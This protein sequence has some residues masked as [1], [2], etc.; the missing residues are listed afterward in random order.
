MKILLTRPLEDS[1]RIAKDLKELNID[2]VISPLLE[3][4]RKRDEEIDYKKYQSVLI[5]SKNAACGLC[6]SAIKKSLPIYCV[7]D[8]T[9]NFI[10]NLGFSNV[11]SASGDVSNLIRLTAANLKPSKGPI[12]YLSGQYIRYDIK[13]ELEYLDFEVD[14]SVIYEAKEVKYFNVDMLKSLEKK[15]ITGVFLYSPR[16]A[17]IFIDNMKRTKL[18]AVAPDLKV[19]C[20]SLAVADELKELKWKKVLIAHKPENAEM[21]ALVRK[22]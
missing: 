13:K 1:Q 19:Y 3:I 21:L 5:T 22:K 2:T 11:I 9:S 15:E 17:R 14:V 12:V 4:H 8:A 6:G 7:G 16:S 20:I 18:T 10:A